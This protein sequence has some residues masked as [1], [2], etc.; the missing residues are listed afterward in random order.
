MLYWSQLLKTNEAGKA[1]LEIYNS[2][3]GRTFQF[4]G[5]VFTATGQPVSFTGT[6]GE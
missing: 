1:K 3:Q 5:E 2:D 4:V 6:V